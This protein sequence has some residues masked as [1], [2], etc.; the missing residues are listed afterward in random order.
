[1][2]GPAMSRL[3]DW[4]RRKPKPTGTGYAGGYAGGY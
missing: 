2:E 4:F 3:L 1:M